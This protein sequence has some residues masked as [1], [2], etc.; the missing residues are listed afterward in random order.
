MPYGAVLNVAVIVA[1]ILAFIKAETNKPRIILAS[2]MAVIILLPQ[3]I[4]MPVASW[5][6]YVHYIGKVVFGLAC[7]VYIKW[8]GMAY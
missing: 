6:W 3:V 7:V 2:I 1:F 5:L 8:A 4:L